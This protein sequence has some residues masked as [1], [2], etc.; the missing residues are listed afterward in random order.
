M[1]KETLMGGAGGASK[2]ADAGLLVLRLGIGLMLAFGHGW[3]KLPPPDMFVGGVRSLGFPAP[4]AFAWAAALSEFLGG[5]LLAVGLF[6]RVGAFFV[7]STMGVAA[8]GQHLRDP[9]FMQNAAG[10]PSKEFAL[11]YLIPAVALLLTGSGRF[12]LDRVI[13]RNRADAGPHGFPA[14]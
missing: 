7:I 13:G 6:T 2:A 3:Y 4:L 12:G 9:L 14:R 5:L 10:G 8:L 1:L 11:L